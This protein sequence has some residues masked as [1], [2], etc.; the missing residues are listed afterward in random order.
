MS[1]HIMIIS[2]NARGKF[3]RDISLSKYNLP[4]KSS[5]IDLTR[6]R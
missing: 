5:T 6:N 2:L 1:I 4:F 3:G